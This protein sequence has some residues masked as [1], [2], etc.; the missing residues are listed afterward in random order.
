LDPQR[1]IRGIILGLTA[2]V[3]AIGKD[4]H[5][6]R[7]IRVAI[8]SSVALFLSFSE[9]IATVRAV[10]LKNEILDPNKE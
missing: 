5:W 6:A 3:I 1:K 10:D 9:V 8:G 2:S 4:T 7:A